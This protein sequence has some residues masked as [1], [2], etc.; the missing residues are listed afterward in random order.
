MLVDQTWWKVGQRSG[1]PGTATAELF[2]SFKHSNSA[3]V[4]PSCAPTPPADASSS[5]ATRI[6]RSKFFISN[7]L[8]RFGQP[9]GAPGQS[10]RSDKSVSTIC[11][12][13][14]EG[15]GPQPP[16]FRKAAVGS[17]QKLGRILRPGLNPRN[18]LLS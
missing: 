4:A 14:S 16:G 15:A 2:A 11:M 10:A 5:D 9:A 13:D 1:S 18:S 17:G 6:E 3:R 12:R 8:F 7:P